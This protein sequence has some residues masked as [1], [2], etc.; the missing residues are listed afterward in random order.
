MPKPHYDFIAESYATARQKNIANRQYYDFW[1]E[2]LIRAIPCNLA[3]ATVLD[4]MSGSCELARIAHNRVGKLYA[5]DV[6][7][8]ILLFQTTDDVQPTA[9]ICADAR[10]LPLDEAT[11]DAVVIRGGLHH[12]PDA[13]LM[14]LQEINRIL[15]PGGWLICSEPFDDNP[16]IN[17][18]RNLLH[19]LSPQFDPEERGLRQEELK[20]LFAQA[21]FTSFETFPFGYLGYTLIG[22]VDVL[23]LF[24]KLHNRQ[25]INILIEM[26]RISPSIPVWRHLALARIIRGQATKI[27]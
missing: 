12:V 22:N 9:K 16:L 5:L 20:K 25:A 10:R 8:R 26:D 14:V 3:E 4:C 19:I 15:K 7:R 23:P 13:I 11:F 2:Q 1:S 6:S 27:S 18:A 24:R 17:L 21:G